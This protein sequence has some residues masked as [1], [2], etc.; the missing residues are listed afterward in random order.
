[1]KTKIIGLLIILFCLITLSVYLI[2]NSAAYLAWSEYKVPEYTVG[3]ID[4]ETT[5]QFNP[6]TILPALEN[7]EV[8]LF[9]LSANSLF[10]NSD[11][12]VIISDYGWED[13]DFWEVANALH[14]FTWKQ[15]LKNWL[16]Y[17]ATYYVARQL[18]GPD[19]IYYAYYI[20]FIRKDSQY[21]V[22]AITIDLISEEATIGSAIYHDESKWRNFEINSLEV[23]T[24]NDAISIADMNT[25]IKTCEMFRDRCQIR[26]WLSPSLYEY[27]RLFS[28]PLYRYEWNWKLSYYDQLGR[29]I[30]TIRVDPTTGEMMP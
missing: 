3:G 13:E 26:A 4:D 20:F 27:D 6:S 29:N 25:E 14:Q 15:P 18:D 2:I 21:I 9:T 28:L 11:A 17:S 30:F 7:G 5:Y 1:M 16:L 8:D 10:Q 24:V 23:Q 22:H 19:I 12:N